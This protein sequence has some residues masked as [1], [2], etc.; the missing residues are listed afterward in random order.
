MRLGVKRNDAGGVKI[1]GGFGLHAD[2][3]PQRV[4][5]FA[6]DVDQILDKMKKP[7]AMWISGK[8]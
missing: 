7:S 6:E 8:K 3:I 4:V 2:K 5:E 1:A